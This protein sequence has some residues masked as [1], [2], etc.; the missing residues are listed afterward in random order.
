MGGSAGGVDSQSDHQWRSAE[1]PH[2]PSGVPKVRGPC[3]NHD[4]IC[5]RRRLRS[6][7]RAKLTNVTHFS[8]RSSSGSLSLC[9]AHSLFLS[10]SRPFSLSLSET[11]LFSICLPFFHML[12]FSL[13][14]IHLLSVSISFTLYY[15]PSL[16]PSLYLSLTLSLSLSVCLSLCLSLLA[17]CQWSRVWAD[18]QTDRQTSGC[19]DS[20]AGHCSEASEGGQDGPCRL[21]SGL[22]PQRGPGEEQHPEDPRDGE[23]QRRGSGQNT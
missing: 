4:T 15:R 7:T 18:R 22:G 6:A 11:F 19:A 12:F 5:S 8:F 20:A 2:H 17:G 13:F 9:L 1:R 10:L 16:S 14:P 3:C 23:I 21:P